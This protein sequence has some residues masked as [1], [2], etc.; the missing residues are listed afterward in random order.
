MLVFSKTGKRLDS[1]LPKDTFRSFRAI[2][3]VAS[4]QGLYNTFSPRSW[5]YPAIAKPTGSDPTVL[6][7][8]VSA[9][10]TWPRK[11]KQVEGFLT[12]TTAPSMGRSVADS[13]HLDDF[14]FDEFAILAGT[15]AAFATSAFGIIV[16]PVAVGAAEPTSFTGHPGTALQVGKLCGC[17][18]SLNMNRK[19]A[20]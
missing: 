4:F 8:L 12:G 2:P 10:Y 15:V 13:C 16:E 11:L 20:T 3:N 1:I 5:A 19:V 6:A 7:L 18:G 14:V 9:S 17:V